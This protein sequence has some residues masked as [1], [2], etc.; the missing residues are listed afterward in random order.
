MN[1]KLLIAVALAAAP[2][3]TTGL[4]SNAMATVE[5]RLTD[6]T[7]GSTSTIIG[8]PDVGG[9]AVTFNGA[10]GNWSINLTTGLSSGPGTSIIDLIPT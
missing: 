3:I 8:A 6:I 1:R 5:L 10:V 9:S 4:A 2:L 7:T